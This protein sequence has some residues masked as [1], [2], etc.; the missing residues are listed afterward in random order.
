MQIFLTK[1]IATRSKYVLHPAS[2]LF[3]ISS[4]DL[5]FPLSFNISLPFLET[6]TSFFFF[7]LFFSKTELSFDKHAPTGIVCCSPTLSGPT[8]QSRASQRA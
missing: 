3:S 7:F 1:R 5:S 4:L 6:G 2:T 8:Y